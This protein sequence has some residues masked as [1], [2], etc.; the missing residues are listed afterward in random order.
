MKKGF[1]LTKPASKIA[2]TSSTIQVIPTTALEKV[3]TNCFHDVIVDFISELIKRNPESFF[4]SILT[5][6]PS[7]IDEFL[8]T[9]KDQAVLIKKL[10]Q[11]IRQDLCSSLIAQF[12]ATFLNF[13]L[14]D[15]E[16]QEIFFLDFQIR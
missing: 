12:L 11:Y 1:L 4:S 9:Y 5:T 7:A 13:F 15:D 10:A 2:S 6:D 8:H 16:C 3:P 14:L